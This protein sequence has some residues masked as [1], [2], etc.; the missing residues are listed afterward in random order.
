MLMGWSASLVSRWMMVMMMMGVMSVV[1][2]VGSR[3]GMVSRQVRLVNVGNLRKL[4]RSLWVWARSS[5]EFS[6][7]MHGPKARQ[8]VLQ[9]RRARRRWQPQHVRVRGGGVRVCGWRGQGRA[10]H[11]RGH[12]MVVVMVMM[13]IVLVVMMRHR[14]SGR[15]GS[16]GGAVSPV[17]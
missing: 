16:G 14:C 9:Q 1:G 2:V 10:P 7:R 13:V 11:V 6:Q 12:R 8:G 15:G 3:N 5:H 17:G 4:L